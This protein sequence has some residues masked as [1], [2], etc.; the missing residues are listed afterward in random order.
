MMEEAGRRLVRS[1]VKELLYQGYVATRLTGLSPQDVRR[2][3][4]A[5]QRSQ[6]IAAVALSVAWLT[7]VGTGGLLPSTSPLLY[8]LIVL[9]GT[10][11]VLFTSLQLLSYGASAGPQLRELLLSLPLRERELR[12]LIARAVLS[13]LKLPLM[14]TCLIVAVGA[15]WLGPWLGAA[16]ILAAPVGASLAS[17]ASYGLLSAYRRL[18]RSRALRELVRV[19]GLLPL[20]LLMLLFA[21]APRVEL[22]MGSALM[23]FVP[24]L[25]LAGVAEGNPLAAALAGAYSVALALAG[26]MALRRGALTLLSPSIPAPRGGSGFRVKLRRPVIALALADFRQMLRS[27]RLIGFIT[28]PV[29][30]IVIGLLV[31]WGGPAEGSRGEPRLI[32]FGANAGPLVL[33]SPFLAYALY[34]TEL[35]ALAYFDTLPLGRL[36]NVQSKLLVTLSFYAAAA[37][38]LG[39]R[40]VLGG[41]WQELVP[42][43]LLSMAVAAAVLYTSAHF[44]STLR[45]LRLGRLGLLNQTA[46]ALVTLLLTS[47]PLALYLAGA[48]LMGDLLRPAL[49]LGLASLAELL[50]MLYVALRQG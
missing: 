18:G 26:I 25:N 2:A 15:W 37:G 36:T 13:T 29:I 42:L 5:A 39:L 49:Y 16:G 50:I 33:L 46:Y 3:V 22:P 32:D 24:L 10:F 8:P 20:V 21:L 9:A 30:Y 1:L 11:M 19:A 44:R 6:Y 23:T 40:Y 48:A 7:V 38:M 27:P 43:A 41:S 35:K 28:L 14:A 47:L 31:R 12:E 17:L 4:R 45:S 34:M